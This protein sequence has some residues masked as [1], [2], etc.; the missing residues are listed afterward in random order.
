MGLGAAPYKPPC[1]GRP[2]DHSC[3]DRKES[4]SHLGTMAAISTIISDQLANPGYHRMIPFDY[5]AW[6]YLLRFWKFRS[7]RIHL[8]G[9]S[10][11]RPSLGIA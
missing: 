9:S 1:R 6:R 4:V 3:R 11:C 2:I 7:N 5:Q 10:G 8:K